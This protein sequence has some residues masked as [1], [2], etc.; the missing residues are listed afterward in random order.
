MFAFTCI[1]ISALIA[2]RQVLPSLLLLA[3]DAEVTLKGD[4]LFFEAKHISGPV[5]DGTAI[6][7]VEPGNA[8]SLSLFLVDHAAQNKLERGTFFL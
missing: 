7:F 4:L 1:I 3:E 2:V 6:L 8:E 5:P